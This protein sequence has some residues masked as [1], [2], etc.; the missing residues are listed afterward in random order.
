[1]NDEDYAK[2]QIRRSRS[3]PR[4]LIKD[5]YVRA[6][7]SQVSGATLDV[8]C[9]AGQI[10]E[11]LPRGSLGLE[12][13]EHLLTHLCEQGL[14]C[15]HFNLSEDVTSEALFGSGGFQSMVLSHVLEHFPSAMRMLRKLLEIAGNHKPLERILIIV[16]TERG[17]A[18]DATHKTFVSQKAIEAEGL[19]ETSHFKLRS[20]KYFPLNQSWLGPH[21]AYHELHLL[22]TRR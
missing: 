3:K 12:S 15:R 22:W 10:L 1:M 20:A 5:F 2:E 11:R 7:L 8:G 14:P 6:V 16:P 9:G 19:Q 18:S 4:R 17:Y 13:N 21:F